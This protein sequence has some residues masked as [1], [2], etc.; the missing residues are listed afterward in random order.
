MQRTDKHTR[1][2]PD[3]MLRLPARVFPGIVLSLSL[4]LAT[5]VTVHAEVYKWTDEYGRV[6]YG[7]RPGHADA[8]QIDIDQQE[9]SGTAQI[10]TD[11]RIKQQRLLQ[12]FAEER[13]IRK[14]EEVDRV[15]DRIRR[16]NTCNKAKHY[17]QE[18]LASGYLY[19]EDELGK[20][21]ILS[22]EEF[23]EHL[24]KTERLIEK[25]CS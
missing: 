2:M 22:A 14:K 21:H 8:D 23:E 15:N 19:E 3:S 10:P 25:Y 4:S 18:I 9:N 16:K 24:G 6:H 20:K 1:Y 12:L 13:E 11:R 17:R 5:P 7:D